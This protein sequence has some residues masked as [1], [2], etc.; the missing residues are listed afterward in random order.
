MK[1]NK[2]IIQFGGLGTGTHQF[3]FEVTDKFFENLEYSEIKTANVLAQIE[4]VKQNTVM[5]LNINISGT[6]ALPCDRC[7]ADFNLPIE[8]SESLYLKHGDPS[9]S[10]DTIIVLPQGETSVD[11]TTEI[12][13]LIA[14]SIP[15]R[16]MPDELGVTDHVCDPEVLKRINNMSVEEKPDEKKAGTDVWDELKKIKFNNN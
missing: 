14:V 2:A 1:P 8:N 7:M 4:L 15:M 11:L 5:S 3:E 6:V 9:E 12:Y 10:N 16:R 13:E